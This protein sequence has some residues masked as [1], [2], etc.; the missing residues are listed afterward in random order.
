MDFIIIQEQHYLTMKFICLVGGD[1]SSNYNK[2]AY[3]YNPI[4]D[5][6]TKL[7]DIPYGFYNGSAVTLNNMI[8]LFANRVNMYSV[9]QT[10]NKSILIKIQN[11]YKTKLTKTLEIY[12]SNAQIYDNNQLLEY[13]VYYGNG[14]EWIKI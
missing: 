8:Y 9:I 11:A 6:Y 7:K 13:P 5:T 1:Y 10:T 14:Q 2:T 12:F 3:K 4:S